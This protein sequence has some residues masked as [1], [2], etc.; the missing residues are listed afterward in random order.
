LIRGLVAVAVVL[1]MSAAGSGWFR[2]FDTAL[3]GYLFGVLFFV[4]ATVYR[5]SVWLQRPPTARLRRRG[6]EALRD[7]ELRSG[8]LRSLPSLVGSNLLTQMF[9]RR[10]STTRWLAH[11]LVFWGC[12]LAVAV[13]FPLTFGWFHFRSVGQQ[14]ALYEVQFTEIGILQFDIGGIVAWMFFHALDISAVLVLAGVGIFLARRLRE[15]GAIATQRASDN[16]ALAGLF[17]VSITGLM[18]TVSHQFLDGAFYSFLNVLHALTVV[19]GLM[20]IPFG[21]LFHIFQ[22]PGNLG[23]AFYQRAADAGPAHTCAR[24]GEPFASA[25]QMGD[26]KEILPQLGFRYDTAGGN[27]QDLCPGCRRAGVALAQ[28]TAVRGFG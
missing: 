22:R 11:Q 3:A 28:T 12:I 1:L 15:P 10:R 23:V 19:L 4:F 25:L 14:A 5:Y 16:L 7:P 18:L 24:C 20:Y 6:W 13:T 9:I 8:N 17:A 21:K 2:W 26:L 27:Y